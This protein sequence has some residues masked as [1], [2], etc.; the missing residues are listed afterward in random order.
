[1]TGRSS[2]AGGSAVG[3]LVGA[4]FLVA[5]IMVLVLGIGAAI[6]EHRFRAEG[7]LA[8][9][10]VI[11]KS[12]ERADRDDNSTT[13]YQIAYHFETAAGELVAGQ[14]EVPLAVWEQ[15]AEGAPVEVQY[16]AGSPERNRLAGASGLEDT[17]V[18]LV[19][20]TLVPAAGG[21]LFWWQER[22]FWRTRVDRRARSVLE[23]EVRRIEAGGRDADGVRQQRVRYRFI[24]PLGIMRDGLSG[25]LAPEAAAEWRRATGS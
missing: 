12:I 11:G 14:G 21:A 25:S 5:G 10:M 3:L 2:G 7:R 8:S 13:R 23:A 19:L 22:A 18:M 6:D 20:G 4:V 16:V 24:D 15:L 9:G 1:M 17:I